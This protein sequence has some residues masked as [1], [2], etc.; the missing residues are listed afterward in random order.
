[1]ENSNIEMIKVLIENFKQAKD[2][3]QKIHIARFLR[4]EAAEI[5]WSLLTQRDNE[6]A[7][8]E[9]VRREAAQE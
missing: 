7:E 5:Y 4:D 6:M 8:A 1:M 9:R 2:L 3:D